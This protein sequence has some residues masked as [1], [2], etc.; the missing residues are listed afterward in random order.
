MYHLFD[1][2]AMGSIEDVFAEALWLLQDN[3]PRQARDVL[4]TFLTT[5]EGDF[6][7][8]AEEDDEVPT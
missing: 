5:D 8:F 1:I 7:C 3:E 6:T 2:T 4:D